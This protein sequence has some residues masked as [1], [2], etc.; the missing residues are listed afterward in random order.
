MSNKLFTGEKCMKKLSYKISLGGIISA[1]SILFMFCTG[2]MPLLAFVIPAFVGAMSIILYVEISTK[3]AVLTY[4][5]ISLLSMFIT[6]DKEAALIY[7]M[8]M[9]FYPIVAE[10]INK[11]GSSVLKWIIKLIIYNVMIILYYQLIIRV[12]AGSELIDDMGDLGRYGVYIYLAITNVVFVI[13]DIA[14][15]NL[16]DLYVNWFRKKILRKI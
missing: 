4:V 7:I 9:G 15:A 12:V 8:F 1:L 11:L 3:W 2:F 14:I 5:V 16:K 13:Y 10:Y 6:P